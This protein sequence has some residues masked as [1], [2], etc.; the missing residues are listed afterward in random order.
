MRMKTAEQIYA[1]EFGYDDF[2]EC[3]GVLHRGI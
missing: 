1:G 3:E 2:E